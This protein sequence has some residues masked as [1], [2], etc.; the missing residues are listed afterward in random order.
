MASFIFHNTILTFFLATIPLSS[1]L[2][3]GSDY[4]VVAGALHLRE[5][6]LDG[7]TTPLEWAF[8]DSTSWNEGG[9]RLWSLSL[10]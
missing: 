7:A 2:A 5:D 6:I 1:S 8:E 3:L 9:H 10:L 4:L